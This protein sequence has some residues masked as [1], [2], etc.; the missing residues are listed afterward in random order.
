MLIKDK[1]ICKKN[2]NRTYDIYETL[3]QFGERV[4]HLCEEQKSLLVYKGKITP[5]ALENLGFK[6]RVKPNKKAEYY[7]SFDEIWERLSQK[8]KNEIA[9]M[10]Y[11]KE[12]FGR[13]VGT[14]EELI[15]DL[16]TF[17]DRY[18]IFLENLEFIYGK[19]LKSKK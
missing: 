8:D 9:T 14:K 7:I 18:D 3:N 11:W 17:E 4:P 13:Y 1:E 6:L 16:D 15:Y 12:A 10:P 5:T 19:K 2:K